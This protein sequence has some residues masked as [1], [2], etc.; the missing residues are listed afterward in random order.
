MPTVAEDERS[1]KH[2]DVRRPL[3]STYGYAD[4]ITDRKP[5]VTLTV[6]VLYRE[7]TSWYTSRQETSDPSLDSC[8]LDLLHLRVCCIS[9][10][11]I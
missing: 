8:Q 9:S 5:T 3:D 10:C 11:S 2:T 1:F 7:Y 4:E 6:T